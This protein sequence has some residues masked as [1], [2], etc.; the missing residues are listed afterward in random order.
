M[1]YHDHSNEGIKWE[2]MA[3]M[4]TNIHNSDKIKHVQGGMAIDHLQFLLENIIRLFFNLER[5]L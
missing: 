2:N 1:E 5:S 4:L 3:N